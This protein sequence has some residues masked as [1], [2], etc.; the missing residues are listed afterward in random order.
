ME[1]GIP[2]ES[3]FIDKNDDE[4]IKLIPF[5]EGLVHNVSV[6]SLFPANIELILVS[7]PPPRTKMSAHTFAIDIIRTTLVS[8]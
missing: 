7:V 3:W 6:P 1:N 4:L 2:I 5:L 8:H